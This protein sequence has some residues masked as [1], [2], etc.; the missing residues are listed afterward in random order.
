[1]ICYS[2]SKLFLGILL[3]SLVKLVPIANPGSGSYK[4]WNTQLYNI[5]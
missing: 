5:R 1:M 3:Y 2:F 4:F